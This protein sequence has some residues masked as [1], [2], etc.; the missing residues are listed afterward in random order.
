[1]L[2]NAINANFSVY[3][4]KYAYNAVFLYV[5]SATKKVGL[6]PTLK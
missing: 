1:M 3:L 6:K 2:I 4:F 5:S